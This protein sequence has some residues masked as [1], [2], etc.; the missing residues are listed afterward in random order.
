MGEQRRTLKQQGRPFPI[1]QGPLGE[2]DRSGV[3]RNGIQRL[4]TNAM[5]SS[6]SAIPSRSAQKP[7]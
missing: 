3:F 7:G 1:G 2:T 5:Y 6:H 4:M